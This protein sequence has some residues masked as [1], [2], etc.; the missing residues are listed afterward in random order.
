MHNFI[1][2]PFCWQSLTNI[3][4]AAAVINGLMSMLDHRTGL[5]SSMLPRLTPLI[6]LILLVSDYRIHSIQ[7]GSYRNNNNGTAKWKPLFEKRFVTASEMRLSNVK[8]VFHRH[9]NWQREFLFPE[10]IS[11][12]KFNPRYNLHTMSEHFSAFVDILQLNHWNVYNIE[13]R[14][15]HEKDHNKYFVI[16]SMAIHL[17]L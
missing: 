13:T 10:N 12:E 16:K 15:L 11:M 1:M 2:L 4:S 6:G 17:N 9:H 7:T 14:F 5:T 8:Q 3:C